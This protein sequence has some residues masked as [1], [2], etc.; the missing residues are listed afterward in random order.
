MDDRKVFELKS[1][2]LAY[3]KQLMFMSGSMII[4]FIG[5]ALYMYNIYRFDKALTIVSV[6]LIMTGIISLMYIDDKL[7]GLSKK[8]RG[9]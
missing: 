2:E 9:L 4:G 3:K 6:V 7:K 8:I 5:L 1:L